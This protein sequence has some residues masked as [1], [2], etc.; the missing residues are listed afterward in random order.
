MRDDP[1]CFLDDLPLD[2][3]PVLAIRDTLYGREDVISKLNSLYQNGA[4]NGLVLR[5]SA[6]IGKS[7][8][9]TTVMANLSTQ[10][11]SYFFETKFEQGSNVNPFSNIAS[12]FNSLC[13]SFAWD[14]TS[15]QLKDVADGL[16]AALGAQTAVL[17]FIVPNLSMILPHSSEAETSTD[18]IDRAASVNYSFRKLLE[19]VSSHSRRLIFLFDDL[20]WVSRWH[21]YG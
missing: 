6:G 19:I 3:N 15:S 16:K 5:G 21:V 8:L 7:S 12:V 17:S 2:T 13:D 14:A 1:S 9:A 4:H 11:E 10:T 18:C 20:Q